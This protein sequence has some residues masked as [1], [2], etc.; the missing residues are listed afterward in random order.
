M[1]RQYQIQIRHHGAWT[2]WIGFKVGAAS[3]VVEAAWAS[4]AATSRNAAR[5]V[6]IDTETGRA[7]VISDKRAGRP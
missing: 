3:S 1:S 2:R 4:H 5:L 6:S 7:R